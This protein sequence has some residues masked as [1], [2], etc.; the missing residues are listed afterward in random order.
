MVIA[1]PHR[2]KIRSTN[3]MRKARTKKISAVV[4]ESGGIGERVV[5]ALS[6]KTDL[7]TESQRAQRKDQRDC[8]TH[9]QALVSPCFGSFFLVFSSAFSLCSL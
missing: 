9:S 7:T 6:G 1:E 3:V 8:R 4:K 2:G 5:D